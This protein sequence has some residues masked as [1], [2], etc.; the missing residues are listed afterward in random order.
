MPLA[1]SHTS[2]GFGYVAFLLDFEE[3]SWVGLTK[4]H[5]DGAILR[6]WSTRTDH[7]RVFS[8][9]AIIEQLQS[10]VTQV[11]QNVTDAYHAFTF[12]PE[13]WDCWGSG[14]PEPIADQVTAV[15]RDLY[16]NHP[17]T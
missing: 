3:R 1:L 12:W 13:G 10:R 8:A 15:L 2:L 5:K 17:N 9:T 4:Q 14:V 7:P 6:F 16:R 11:E